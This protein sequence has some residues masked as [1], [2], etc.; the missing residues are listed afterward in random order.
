MTEPDDA[1]LWR[2]IRA[3]DADAFRLLFD[4][5]GP[6][7]HRYVLRRSGDPGSADDITAVVFLEAWRMRTRTDLQQ[8][9]SLPWLY[10][11]A[12]NVLRH[13]QR[14]R[15]R[16][17]EALAR[18]ALLPSPKP[19]LVE[20]QAQAAADA[21]AVLEQITR[22]PARERD[23]LLLSVWE[24]LSHAEIALALGT[25]VGTVKSRL[26]RARARLDP[27]RSLPPRPTSVHSFDTPSPTSID[28]ALPA[29]FTTEI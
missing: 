2:R 20:R 5:H 28:P 8:T 6:R 27:D 26:S 4:R 24:G 29:A 9:T 13:W 7:I 17:H 1:D 23:V 12:G 10:G 16:H 21:A 18:F 14:S 19:A 25:T 15:R 11:V 3:D 22:L